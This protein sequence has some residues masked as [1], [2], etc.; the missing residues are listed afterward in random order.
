MRRLRSCHR[1]SSSSTPSRRPPLP[2]VSGQ[3]RHCGGGVE[4]Q[5]ARGHQP[6]ALRDRARSARRPRPTGAAR[7]ARRA[8][9]AACLGLEHRRRRGAAA[10]RRCR[11]PRRPRPA[12]ARR[13]S[14]NTLGRVRAHR[15]ELGRRRRVRAQVLVGEVARAE[16]ERRPPRDAA[17]DRADRDLGRAAADVDDADHGPRARCPSVRVAPRNASRASSS[18]SRIETSTPPRSLT[19]STNSSRLAAARI[20]AVATVRTGCGPDLLGELAVRGDDVGH[21]LDLRAR[22]LGPRLQALADPRERP[23]LQH[24]AQPAVAGVGDEHA[25]RVRADV[26]AAADHWSGGE[27]AMMGA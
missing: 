18:P 2:I 12:A 1:A 14:S 27:V 19:T 10:R 13:A 8:P 23:P 11:R 15:G 26:D 20:A 3:P 4:D 17:L 22:D 21:L 6:D 5:H 25:R 16:P 24:L 9:A 7:R